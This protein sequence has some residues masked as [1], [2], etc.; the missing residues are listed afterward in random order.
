MSTCFQHCL[1]DTRILALTSATDSCSVAVA[2]KN[3]I[4]S[5]FAFSPRRHNEVIFDLCNIVLK[6]AGVGLKEIDTLVYGRGPGGFTGVRIAASIVKTLAYCLRVPVVG[7]SD[8]RS[9]AQVALRRYPQCSS[10]LV[11]NDARMD[12]AYCGHFIRDEQDRAELVGEESISKPP[13]PP[14]RDCRVQ[15][16]SSD[17]VVG[18]AAMAYRSTLQGFGDRRIPFDEELH[19][20]ASSMIYLATPLITSGKVLGYAEVEPL[21]LRNRL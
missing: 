17:L 2:H 9:V 1:L 3:R 7:I 15:K 12:E 5:R 16:W 11:A 18:S 8:L 6:E 10:I 20:D 14:A 21:Y 19:P 13:S 4:F